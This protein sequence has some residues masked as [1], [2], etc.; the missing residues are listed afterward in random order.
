VR[1]IQRLVYALAIILNVAVAISWTAI[2][3]AVFMQ[4]GV[5]LSF[6]P[7]EILWCLIPVASILALV[8]LLWKFRY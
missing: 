6:T 2:V 8:A 3:G 1:R 5:S 4:R 7:W